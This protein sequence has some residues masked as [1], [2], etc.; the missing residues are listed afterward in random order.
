[1]FSSAVGSSY[2]VDVQIAISI[3]V[4]FSESLAHIP[5]SKSIHRST[6]LPQEFVVLNEAIAVSIKP[7]EKSV[8]L[9]LG[10]AKHKVCHRFGKFILVKGH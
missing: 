1:M 4:H 5:G 9:S 8:N 7:S 2:V 10:E 3:L 6:D